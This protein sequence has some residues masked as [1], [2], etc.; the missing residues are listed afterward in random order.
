MSAASMDDVEFYHVSSEETEREDPRHT[1]QDQ[2]TYEEE[3]KRSVFEP[4]F[5]VVPLLTLYLNQS[6]N[7][8]KKR[9]QNAYKD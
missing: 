5:A 1:Q 2:V 6:I 7:E 4:C 9:K 3:R 8:K